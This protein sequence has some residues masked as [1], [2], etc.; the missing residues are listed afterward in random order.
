MKNLDLGT[1]GENWA[2]EYLIRK[3]YKIIERNY[4][5]EKAEIDIIAQKDET[6]VFIEVK[7]RTNIHFGFPEEFV[8]YKKRNLLMKAINEYISV[9][10]NFKSI[11]FDIIS[12]ILRNNAPQI[13]HFEDAWGY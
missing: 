3:N 8:N 9:N 13:T 5:F 7:L 11:R 6:L 12:I 10:Q 2:C 4:R 1:K